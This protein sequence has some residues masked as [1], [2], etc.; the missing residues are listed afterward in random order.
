MTWAPLTLATPLWYSAERKFQCHILPKTLSLLKMF[1]HFSLIHLL[2]QSYF[3]FS[4]WVFQLLKFVTDLT[5][6]KPSITN[7][8]LCHCTC[9]SP[10]QESRKPVTKGALRNLVNQSLSY[11]WKTVQ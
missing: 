8:E 4:I 1:I 3:W 6:R 9:N 2:K 10:S 7:N 11:S 5:V